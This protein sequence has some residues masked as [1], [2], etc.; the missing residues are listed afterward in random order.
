MAGSLEGDWQ[1][2]DLNGGGAPDPAIT[3][4]FDGGDQNNRLAGSSGCNRFS[5]RWGQDG[6]TLKLGPFAATRMACAPAVLAVE[7]RFLAVLGDVGML[8]FTA[9]GEAILTTRDGRRL[10]LR[11]PPPPAS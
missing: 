6:R 3:L 4:R 5:G 9:A 10:L 1:L 7:Q 11:R 2:A 8:Q